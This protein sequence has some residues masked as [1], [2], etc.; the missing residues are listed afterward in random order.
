MI[1]TTFKLTVSMMFV[2]A[3][4]LAFGFTNRAF[5]HE[6]KTEERSAQAGITYSYTAQPSDSY[7]KVARK[8]V[9]TYGLKEKI[10]LSQAGIIYAETNLALAAGSPALNV[11]QKVE[12][13]ESAIHE[14]VDKASKLTEAQTAAWNY[15]VQF[16]D[17]NTNNVGES[18]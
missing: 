12:I 17:F 16:V 13:K 5:A 6:Q 9:Q 15:Y 11:G 2:I 4:A 10:N 8:A 14:W 7:S 18:R 1:L 3:A